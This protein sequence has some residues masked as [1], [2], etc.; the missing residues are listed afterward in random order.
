MIWQR[1]RLALMTS[2]VLA[3]AQGAVWAD[4]AADDEDDDTEQM[5]NKPEEKPAEAKQ[6]G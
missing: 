3:A 6:G 5:D 2:V 4:D 1:L